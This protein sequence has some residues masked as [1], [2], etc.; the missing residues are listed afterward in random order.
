M[1]SLQELK[2]T[3][4]GNRVN[5]TGGGGGGG[6]PTDPNILHPKKYLDP[7]LCTQKN[8]RL[9]ILD[10]DYSNPAFGSCGNF[11]LNCV[12][13]ISLADIRTQKDTCRFFRPKK[14]TVK[15]S[16]QKNT[17]VENFRPP[18]PP[19]QKKKKNKNVGHPR[20]V[21]TRESPLGKATCY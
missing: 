13:T 9:E 15:S 18:P 20:H 2:S 11:G 3:P 16:T 19:P 4:G 5:V 7:I 10:A 21:Y 8:T 12:R 14:H 6:G 17:G 1:Q